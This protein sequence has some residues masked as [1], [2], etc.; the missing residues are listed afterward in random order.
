[1]TKMLRV[2]RSIFMASPLAA[3]VADPFPSLVNQYYETA[4]VDS[5][6]QDTIDEA[7]RLVQKYRQYVADLLFD[8]NKLEAD[9]ITCMSF[10]CGTAPNANSKCKND[11]ACAAYTALLADIQALKDQLK[12]IVRLIGIIDENLDDLEFLGGCEGGDPLDPTFQGFLG[13]L[14]INIA[15]IQKAGAG[16]DGMAVDRLYRQGFLLFQT[17]SRA[18]MGS[19]APPNIWTGRYTPIGDISVACVDAKQRISDEIYRPGGLN[20][21]MQELFQSMQDLYDLAVIGLVAACKGG[22]GACAT[23]WC[24]MLKRISDLKVRSEGFVHFRWELLTDA[25][26]DI[27]CSSDDWEDQYADAQE[28]LDNLKAEIASITADV[29]E[30]IADRNELIE[31]CPIMPAT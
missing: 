28:A 16:I 25:I 11:D 15:R 20:D 14:R 27:D 31:A 6:C 24:N 3:F 19:A 26:A 22:N 12:W 5:P 23:S 2:P 18:C 7:N 4:L 10:Y 13:G 21:Q 17:Y 29:A 9:V 30:V 8:L 1:M